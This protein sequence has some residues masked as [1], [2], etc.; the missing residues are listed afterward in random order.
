MSIICL[1]NTNT[2]VKRVLISTKAPEMYVFVDVAH[3]VICYS[4]TLSHSN[5]RVSMLTR[6][7]WLFHTALYWIENIFVVY[8][9]NKNISEI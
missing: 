1:Q 6:L 9:L 7:H 4:V 2:C 8:K 5:L 3:A